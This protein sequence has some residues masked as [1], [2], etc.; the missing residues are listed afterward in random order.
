LWLGFQTG[1]HC[2]DTRVTGDVRSEGQKVIVKDR[3]GSSIALGLAG[4]TSRPPAW[5]CG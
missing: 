1:G 3:A 2:K 5:S 4:E